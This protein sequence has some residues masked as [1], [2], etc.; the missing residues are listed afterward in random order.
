MEFRNINVK[1]VVMIYGF[2]FCTYVTSHNLVNGNFRPR[3]HS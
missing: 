2:M 1:Y 3:N